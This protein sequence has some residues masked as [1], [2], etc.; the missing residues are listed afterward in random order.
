MNVEGESRLLSLDDG[1]ALHAWEGGDADGV[2]IAFHPGTP[3]GRLQAVLG[4]ESARQ[5]GVRL[6]SLNR[7][8]YGR[9]TD[10]P[11]GLASVG[12]DTM[13]VADALGIDR[14]AVLGASGGG[15]YALATGLA[16]PSRVLAIG[17]V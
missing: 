10:T 13:R 15:P 16:D 14:F 4:A 9:S 6:V 1:R 2:P 12:L 11:P 5:V 7:P 8:G 3:S 17:V